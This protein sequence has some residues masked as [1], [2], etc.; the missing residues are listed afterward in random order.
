MKNENQNFKINDLDTLPGIEIISKRG[1]REKHFRQK[2]GTCIAQ[3][4]SD[5]IHFQKN[6]RYEEID[7]RLEKI[8]N[9]YKNKKNEFNVYFKECSDGKFLGYEM[10]QGYLGFELVGCNNV[11]LQIIKNDSKTFQVVKYENIIEGID[12]EYKIVS[13]KVKEN[14]IIKEEK[15]VPSQL[16]FLLNTDLELSLN[17]NGISA[18]KNNKELFKMDLPYIIDAQ[19]QLNYNVYYQLDKI[20]NNT[21]KLELKLHKD[22]LLDENM[23]YPI[24]IDPTITTSNSNNV[25]DFYIFPGDTNYNHGSG[26]LMIAGVQMVSGNEVVHRCL[27]K[28][29]LPS[30]STSSQ[31]SSAHLCLIGYPVRTSQYEP[32]TVDIHRITTDWNENGSK[33]SQMHDKYDSRIETSGKCIRSEQ[34]DNDNITFLSLNYYD[35]TSLVKKWYTGTPNYG[36]MIKAHDE[37]YNNNPFTPIFFTKEAAG[38]HVEGFETTPTL[39]ITYKDQS[40][41]EDYMDY[42]TQLFS[43]GS[44]YENTYNGNLIASF[45]IGYTFGNKYPIDLEIIYN[46]N[47]VVLNK[48]IGYGRGYKINYWQ[49]IKK[50]TISGIDYL[51]YYD[52]NGTTHYFLEENDIYYDEDGL[53]M[54]ISDNNDEYVLTDKS[55]NIL[56][57]TKTNNV[58]YLTKCTNLNNDNI[59][60]YYDSNNRITKIQDAD[61]DEITFS[62]ETN[63]VKIISPEN[64]YNLNYTEDKLNSISSANGTTYFEYNNNNLIN[65]ITD[66]NKTSVGYLYYEQ[67]P[68]RVKKVIEYGTDD[69]EGS[70]FEFVY[71]N[72]VT[73]ITDNKNRVT[74]IQYNESG[75]AISTSDL[76]ANGDV[77]N[78][79]GAVSNYGENDMQKNKILSEQI[80][81]KHVKNHLTNISFENDII[82]FNSSENVSKTISTDYARSGLKSLKLETALPNENLTQTVTVPKGDYYTL[83]MYIKNTNNIKFSLSYED[84]N[85]QLV[86]E[87]SDIIYNNSEFTRE[88][89]TIYY[90]VDA[91]SDLTIKIYLID[92]GTTYI[93]DIQLESG[94]VANSFNFIENSDFSNGFTDW[95][96]NFGESVTDDTFKVVS[97]ENNVTALKIN[98]DPEKSTSMRK[99]LDLSGYKDDTL[100]ISFWYKNE[101]IGSE[102]N[103]V[104]IQFI[105]DE[106]QPGHGLYTIPLNPNENDWQ[107]FS[108]SYTAEAPYSQVYV[109]LFQDG[110]ANSLYVTNLS[111]FKGRKEE[112][113]VY[114]GNGNVSK[115]TSLNGNDS[116]LKYDESNQVINIDEKDGRKIMFEYDNII[117]D[118]L[119]SNI[120]SSGISNIIKYDNSNNISNIKVVRNHI[121][122]D[123]TNGLYQIRAKGT[124]KYINLLKSGIKLSKF[125]QKWEVEKNEDFYKIS[126]PI[127][128]NK[129]FSFMNDN[130][131]ICGFSDNCSQFVLT[132]RDNGSYLVQAEEKNL[133]LNCDGDY[134]K[135]APWDESK[136]YNYE[137]YFEQD[138]KSNFIE[139]SAEY[140]TDGKFLKNIIDTN[141]NVIEYDI[142]PANGLINSITD[143]NGNAKFYTYNTQK[144]KTLSTNGDKIINYYY[145]DNSLLKRIVQGSR[146]YNFDYDKFLN[147]NST[148]IGDDIVL[149][150][151]NYEENDGNLISINYGNNQSIFYEYDEFDRIIKE[152]QMENVYYLKYGNHGDLLKIISNDGV[153]TYD[154][155]LGKRLNEYKN[156]DFKIRYTY[157]DSDRIVNVNYKLGEVSNDVQSTFNNADSI[158]QTTFGTNNINYQFDNLERVTS[159]SI[160]NMYL[161]KYSYINNGYRNS[162]LVKTMENGNHIYSYKYDKLKNV[163]HIYYNG[164]LTKRYYY[165][166]YN[167]LIK[168]HNFLNNQTITY[169]Y[170]IYG[171]I[172]FKN[173]YKLKTNELLNQIK[174]EYNNKNWVDQLTKYDGSNITY[175]MIGNPIT[176][177]SNIVL[178]WT[179][180]RQLKQY[181]NSSDT[182]NYKYNRDGIRISKTINSIETQYFLEDND[183]IY[184]KTGNNV[185]YYIRNDIDDLIGFKLNDV[186]YYYVKNIFG[187]IIEIL[188]S[189]CNLVARYEYGSYGEII[190]IMD[191]EG[192]DISDDFSHIANINP[193]RYRSYYYDK[194]TGLYYLNS[195][196]YNP[197][198]GRFINADGS[199]EAEED[200]SY[201]MYSYVLNN[202]INMIDPNGSFGWFAAIGVALTI[203]SLVSEFTKPKNERTV[204]STVSAI[205]GAVPGLNVISKTS[206]AAKVISTVSKTSSSYKKVTTS[207]KTT[208]QWTVL[209]PINKKKYNGEN[210][211]WATV[212]RRYWKQEAYYNSNNYTAEALARMQRGQ[213]PLVW[214][215]K[216]KK[217]MSMEIHHING[218]KISDPHNID[219]LQALT[220]AQH[221]K[222]DSFRARFYGK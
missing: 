53:N 15:Y 157:D 124:S 182:I 74:V 13:N 208:S 161:I 81:I 111:L 170:D 169:K 205:A 21:Y 107:F 71:G 93:D 60:I 151:N 177:G 197:K 69:S 65:R 40:G 179:N 163:T 148:K 209:E 84:I 116:L 63:M 199:V 159:S 52:E 98:M 44:T 173:I 150:V 200:T 195:R 204:A 132:K 32:I 54:S 24:T 66:I 9:Y 85:H 203:I 125:K 113:Y 37:V 59:N 214:D 27:V 140:S 206:K 96:L 5:D 155:D 7:N 73:T 108:V 175:D 218:R 213:A 186:L 118:K 34:D 2:D 23:V 62:Y 26:W 202:P 33:W 3:M 70:S 136:S 6:G 165:D 201:N 174:Y 146:V 220:P 55:G 210:P 178:S 77:N 219:N 198:W 35:I 143:Q 192:Y 134:I 187:D 102:N 16:V 75:N 50:V 127:L 115:I 49:T 82:N 61:N 25:K 184:E 36:V 43:G 196:Y 106:E 212:R 180:G 78:A 185:I 171:N 67:S 38:N 194:E 90:P 137:F 57:F 142:D 42:R 109:N 153:E 48:D 158:V 221:A 211:T 14:V 56:R 139:S 114:D 47:D 64:T 95:T 45:E 100:T 188:D 30:I 126:H 104:T 87:T 123:I 130:L 119:I 189:N 112:N 183:I 8:E 144:Q 105:Y 20:T 99:I 133:Y 215:T 172:L 12:F 91:T 149:S 129:F 92:S 103:S 88:N 19:N 29:D 76:K 39:E 166:R 11:P 79:Y 191:A 1:K 89:V 86:E 176:I 152:T 145:N 207:K 18:K 22:K 51:E 181:I 97:L 217:Y 83:S 190:S 120:S 68:Y 168:E 17:D 164:I 128:S 135:M 46:T 167:E 193:F 58:G 117:K 110:D 122:D 162:T 121:S 28:I 72:K 156:N 131:A 138:D 216:F 154:Y 222:V 94:E 4:Y 10:S 31:I 160:N 101:G 80:P 141:F 147:K 41:L